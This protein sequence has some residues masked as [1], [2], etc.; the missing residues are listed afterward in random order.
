[1][2]RGAADV[3]L[4]GG[5][6]RDAELIAQPVCP[7]RVVLTVAPTSPLVPAAA[8]GPLPLSRLEHETII[9]QA[10]PSP[11]WRTV[12]HWAAAH[13]VDLRPAIRLDGVEAVKKTVEADMGVAFL[14]GWVVERELT[15]GTL[16]VLPL[17][18]PAPPRHYV[19]A[20]HRGRTPGPPLDA[21][22]RFGPGYL[23]NHLPASVG[24]GAGLSAPRRHVA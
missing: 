13:G 20:F 23:Q 2:T 9:A 3:A 12:E 21:L 14:S 17:D 22:L 7:D 18:P 4:L 24:S 6:L 8:L 15:L 19:L 1:V 10:E 16:R 11:S 5:P